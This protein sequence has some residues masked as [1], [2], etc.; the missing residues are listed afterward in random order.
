MLF[1][2]ASK[3]SSAIE[4]QYEQAMQ[5]IGKF[6]GILW[7]FNKPNVFIIQDR[8]TVHALRGKTLQKESWG[9]FMATPHTS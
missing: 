3:R 5:D 8:K 6:F 7:E 4:K 9:G 1:T 2:L